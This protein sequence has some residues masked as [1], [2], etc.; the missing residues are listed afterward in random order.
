MLCSSSINHHTTKANEVDESQVQVKLLIVCLPSNV[1]PFLTFHHFTFKVL[2]A[3]KIQFKIAQFHQLKRTFAPHDE[4][5]SHDNQ[6]A[7]K[8]IQKTVLS[9]QYVQ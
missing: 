6:A 5:K 4:E 3:V 2:A 9:L 1:T 8:K 7:N